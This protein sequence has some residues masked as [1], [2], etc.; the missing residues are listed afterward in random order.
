MAKIKGSNTYGIVEIA[1]PV[2]LNVQV[3]NNVMPVTMTKLENGTFVSKDVKTGELALPVA[4]KPAY[5]VA[6][7]VTLYDKKDGIGDFVNKRDS[8]MPRLIGLDNAK[9]T[10]LRFSDVECAETGLETFAKIATFLATPSNKL[11]AHVD[12]TTGNVKIVKTLPVD[13]TTVPTGFVGEVTEV[14]VMRNGE[15]GI[16]VYVQ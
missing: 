1:L 10:Y 12:A 6:S 13:L 8:Y 7:D 14:C 9:G 15:D 2:G 5:L 3:Q 16:E 11:Y 4:G